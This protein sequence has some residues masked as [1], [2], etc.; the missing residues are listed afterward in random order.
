MLEKIKDAIFAKYKKEDSKGLFFSVFDDKNVLILSNGALYTDKSLDDLIKTL[1]VGLVEKHVNAKTI[2]VD[3]VLE[4]AKIIDSSEL[5]KISLKDYGLL[6]MDQD[7]SGVLLPDTKG[8]NSI[9]EWLK[10]IKEKNDLSNNVQ[11]I[12]FKTDRTIVN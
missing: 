3:V 2:V 6:L 5:L 11:I 10:I 8:V 9:Q 4:T 7:K 12:K 1:Y